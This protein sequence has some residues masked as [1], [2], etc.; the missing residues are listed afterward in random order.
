M[1]QSLLDYSFDTDPRK[2]I[3][4]SFENW[5]PYV[6]SKYNTISERYKG[7]EKYVFLLLDSFVHNI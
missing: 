3:N 6:R 1:L 7:A 2:F 4:N 5:D